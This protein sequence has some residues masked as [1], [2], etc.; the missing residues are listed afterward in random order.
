MK[1]LKNKVATL[2]VACMA[3]ILLGT[4]V[5]TVLAAPRPEMDGGGT[6]EGTQAVITDRGDQVDVTFT[7]T[8]IEGKTVGVG[9]FLFS[10][11][12]SLL[13]LVSTSND[14]M[15][16]ANRN[17]S[18]GTTEAYITNAAGGAGRSM[19]IT[20]TFDDCLLG[21][22]DVEALVEVEVRDA[23]PL[24]GWDAEWGQLVEFGHTQGSYPDEIEITQG[25]VTLNV[26]VSVS[27]TPTTATVV[28]GNSETFTASVTNDNGSGVTWSVTGATS[29]STVINSSGQ[30]TVGTDET[31]TSLTVT[32]TA[33]NTGTNPAT[34]TT[35]LTVDLV[36]IS[37]AAVEDTMTVGKGDVV[38]VAVI[39]TND[40]NS[41]G[42]VWSVAGATSSDTTI[43]STG[44]LTVGAD[45]MAANLT[46]TATSVRDGSKSADITVTVAEKY[47]ITYRTNAGSDLVTFGPRSFLMET[48]HLENTL[49]YIHP[50]IPLREGYTFVEWNTKTDGSGNSY[51]PSQA[52]V[53]ADH[54]VLHAIWEVEPIVTPE[55]N[56]PSNPNTPST[57]APNTGVTAGILPYLGLA[58][59]S[60]GGIVFIAMKKRR[61]IK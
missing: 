35:S 37:V 17:V 44:K 42:V 20:L 47:T 12:P 24:F 5:I 33:S 7:F 23:T 51:T 57:Q 39:V 59:T 2:L 46:V 36:E 6:I 34:A 55:P 29:A 4:N 19:S 25:K 31:A 43:D 10:W 8:V 26:P 16:E 11:D 13:T 14:N 38:N 22:T 18:G 9:Y 41:D 50:F 21:V 1:M 3:V 27:V 30:L 48:Q 54:V 60:L 40:L 15:T 49:A 58:G 45:E 53:I 28:K 52:F 61:E 56:E 32:A